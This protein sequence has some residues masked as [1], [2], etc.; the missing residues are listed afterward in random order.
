MTAEVI[1]EV[2]A[3]LR[4]HQNLLNYLSVLGGKLEDRTQADADRDRFRSDADA[5]ARLIQ[6]LQPKGVRKCACRSR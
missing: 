6:K 1:S 5:V 4:S 2:I 3:H